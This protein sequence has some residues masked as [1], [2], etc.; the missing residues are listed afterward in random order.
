[1]ASLKELEDWGRAFVAD[2]DRA[3]NHPEPQEKV[4][5]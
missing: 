4:M 1:M 3:G 5:M 2:T